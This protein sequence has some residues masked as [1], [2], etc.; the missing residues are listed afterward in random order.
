[1]PAA[2]AFG[3]VVLVLLGLSIP[4]NSGN[5]WS[6][7]TAWAV[8]AV[9]A[10]LVCTVPMLLRGSGRSARSL[11]SIGAAGAAGVLAYWVLLVLPSVGSNQGF[12]LTLAAALGVFS[13]WASPLRPR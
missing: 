6:T 5:A 2:A 11:W 12:V 1:M 10:A 9:L 7:H 3:A 4:F 13:S 8:F